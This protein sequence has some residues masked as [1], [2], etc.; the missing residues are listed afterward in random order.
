MMRCVVLVKSKPGRRW[1]WNV[2]S[3]AHSPGAPAR[4]FSVRRSLASFASFRATD[5][6]RRACERGGRDLAA[7]HCSRHRMATARLRHTTAHTRP[8]PTLPI[9]RSLLARPKRDHCLHAFP[10]ATSRAPFRLLICQGGAS[11]HPATWPR[12]R[13]A[14]CTSW[15]QSRIAMGE[16]GPIDERCIRRGQTQP[17]AMLESTGS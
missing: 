5:P 13:S 2:S 14:I 8:S 12:T 11:A 1:K 6:Q 10:S 3:P 16:V 9:R 15:L 4:R 17:D 7:C